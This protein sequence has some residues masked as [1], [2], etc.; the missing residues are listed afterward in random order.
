[1]KPAKWSDP[2]HKLFPHQ[3]G[4]TAPP[5]DFDAAPSD[6][7]R[8]APATV[9][10][11]GRLLH[12]P[13]YA[14]ELS[15]RADNLHL[16][17]EVAD[18]LSASGVDAIGQVG[19]NWV[20]A[21]GTD[22]DDIRAFCRRLA[23]TYETPFHMAGLCLVEACAALDVERIALNSVYFWP[24]WRDGVVRFLRSAGLDVVWYGNFVDQGFYNDQQTVND[25]TWIFPGGLA[26][27]SMQRVADAAP[28]AEAIVVNGMP[29]WR[30]P[31]G[32]PE[33]TVTRAADLEAA[34]GLPV[35]AAD[36][37]LYWALFKSLDITPVGDQGRLLAGLQRDLG[38]DRCS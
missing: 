23:D 25:R 20:H 17:E 6:F 16:L 35:I 7:L 33:R 14:H 4:F 8:I 9:G 10:V 24:D 31:D 2:A 29:N 32:L 3:V 21:G 15:Q 12:V 18:C 36:L 27:E 26:L 37:A 5:R 13:G 34:I 28:S 30:R 1:M 38:D 22:A 19:T 11:H